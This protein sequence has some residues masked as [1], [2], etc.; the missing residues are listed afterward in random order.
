MKNTITSK[1]ACTIAHQIRRETGCSLADAFKAAYASNSTINPKTNWTR[2][3][4]DKI[5]S[6]KA[7]E[8]LRKGYL[9]DTDH[10]GGSQGEVAK[11][12]FRK[13]GK[14]YIL[15]MENNYSYASW[16]YNKM[17]TIK[18]GVNTCPAWSTVWIDKMEVLWSMSVVQLSDNYFVTEELSEQY[19]ELNK[20]RYH[21]SLIHRS[22][23]VSESYHKVILPLV[24]KQK[25]MKSMKLNNILKVRRLTEVNFQ[26]QV[27]GRYYR[28]FTDKNDKNGRPVV[29]DIRF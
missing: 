15:V 16:K 24:R 23:D 12:L 26:G 25:G 28:V 2:D 9:I 6:D 4:L 27:L 21:N 18:F 20:T 10:M 11:V 22:V 5:F 3:E 14:I 19:N 13:D 17:I 29:I 7:A 1:Q 8:L